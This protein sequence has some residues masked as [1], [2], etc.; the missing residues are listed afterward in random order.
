MKRPPRPDSTRRGGAA[1]GRAAPAAADRPAGRRQRGTSRREVNR[2]ARTRRDRKQA[3]EHRSALGP[4]GRDAVTLTGIT[5]LLA[6]FGLVMSFSASFVDAAEAGDPFGTFRR[7]SMWAGLGAVGFIV[8]AKVPHRFWRTLAWPLLGAAILG[9]VLVLIPGIGVERFGSSRWLGI[10]SVAIQPSEITKLAVLLWLADVLDRKRPPTGELFSVDHLYV[11]A[12]PLLLITGSL[13]F[14]Q[15]DLGTTVLL[16]LIV[17]AILWVEG[18]PYRHLLWAGVAVLTFVAV[19]AMIAPYRMARITGWLNPEQDPLGSGFQL[20]QAR[21]ALGSGGLWGIGLGASRGKWN[22][23][24]N[25]ETD[26][27]FAI[28]GEELGFIGAVG[29]LLLFLAM[30]YVGLRI[31]FRAPDMFARTVAFAITAWIVG[32]ALVNVGTVTGL[33]PITGVTLPLVSV[34]GSSLT[35]T[36]VTLGILVAISRAQIDGRQAVSPTAQ[37]SSLASSGR[38]GGR[39]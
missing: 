23:V 39:Q 16:A 18:L 33:L 30:L 26:F 29:V 25:P 14:V 37:A 10:G 12:L 34:G 22:F 31:A 3:R 7:Q 2:G 15:P 1:A 11:P 36:L 5:L 4:W 9:L 8:A 27:I 17:G 21:Y 35:V 38:R 6:T 24:P 28:I 20:L 13:V 32:Q 19:A